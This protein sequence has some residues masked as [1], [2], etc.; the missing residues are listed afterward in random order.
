MTSS[1]LSD[2]AE[3]VYL[4]AAAQSVWTTRLLLE[5]CVGT[6]PLDE[7]EVRAVLGQLLELR[8]LHPAAEHPDTQVRV[9]APTVGLNDRLGDLRDRV[10]DEQRALD[11]A[12]EQVVRLQQ[13]Y[14][15]AREAHTEHRVERLTG[16]DAVRSQLE[17][18][19]QGV[20]LE[21]LSFMRGAQTLESMQASWPLDEQALLRGVNLRSVYLHSALNDPAT[22]A[23]LRRLEAAGA[24][25]RTVAALP[26]QLLLVDRTTALVPI[27][28]ENAAAGALVVRSRGLVTALLALFEGVWATARQL[29][30]PRRT[31]VV[32]L[33]D[34]EREALRILRTGATDEVVARQLGVSVRT[35]RRLMSLLLSRFQAQS[36]FELG[37]KLG[38]QGIDP[39]DAEPE[40]DA[41]PT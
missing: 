23:Y 38:Q 5:Q 18:L 34:T 21:A 29:G 12:V 16:L 4:L 14:T 35:V 30:E 6:L 36:R 8:L 40:A 2:D 27:D 3:A 31:E 10:Q 41:V 28:H 7:H 37:L 11:R 9:V 33:S 39:A 20:Q 25:T 13:A 24:Q 32:T 1:E 17:Q 22:V 26:L 19:A 15:E